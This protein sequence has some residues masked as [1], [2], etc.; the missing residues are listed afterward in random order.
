MNMPRVFLC[1]HD[2]GYVEKLRES[3]QDE[4]G[5]EVC[6]VEENGVE[7]V[8]NAGKL[9]P[10]LVILEMESGPE[11]DFYLADA[12]KLILPRVPLFLVTDQQNLESEKEALSQG[13]DALFDEEWDLTPLLLN[14]R[15][16]VGL[17]K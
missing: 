8:K 2:V 10:D 6:E 17:R 12:I 16:T 7:T 5:F 9:Q 15:A 4:V 14:A 11:N 3:F 13:A 1:G